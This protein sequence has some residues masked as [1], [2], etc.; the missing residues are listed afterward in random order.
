MKCVWRYTIRILIAIDQLVNTIFFGDPDETISSRAFRKHKDSCMWNFV[1][2]L[3]DFIFF[4]DVVITPTD[5]I[6][7]C[8]LS[9]LFYIKRRHS[10]VLTYQQDMNSLL[11]HI[12]DHPSHF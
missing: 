5:T 6:N 2:S 3:I 10:T 12:K 11:H 8:E 9:F 7:H 1:K 4:F